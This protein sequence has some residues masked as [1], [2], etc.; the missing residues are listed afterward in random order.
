M[1]PIGKDDR[2]LTID[3]LPKM[4]QV[5]HNHSGDF[6]RPIYLDSIPDHVHITKLRDFLNNF[7]QKTHRHTFDPTLP[8][9]DHI[10]MKY[11][12]SLEFIDFLEIY[13][14]DGNKHEF[15]DLNISID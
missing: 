9:I 13:T 1:K 15:H 10:I 3:E 7:I 4:E 14:N 11:H 6:S 2:T 5:Y 12:P 8:L